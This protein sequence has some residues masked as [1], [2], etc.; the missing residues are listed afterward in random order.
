MTEGGGTGQ[1]LAI[2]PTCGEESHMEKTGVYYNQAG[3]SPWMITGEMSIILSIPMAQ[4]DHNITLC[5]RVQKAE[6]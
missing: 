2:S 1:M 6:L 3:I 5:S 4:N